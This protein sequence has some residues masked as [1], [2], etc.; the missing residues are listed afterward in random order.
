VFVAVITFN[1][2]GASMPFEIER[3]G[4]NGRVNGCRVRLRGRFCFKEGLAIWRLCHPHAFRCQLYY[5]DLAEV[6][7][8]PED[9]VAWLSMFLRWAEEAGVSVRLVNAG[10]QLAEW[11]GAV[12]ITEH[13]TAAGGDGYGRLRKVY[14]HTGNNSAIE[15]GDVTLEQISIASLHDGKSEVDVA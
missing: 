8:L 2:G 9:A 3:F 11:L 15:L 10:P 12:G 6:T 1:E 5:V 13:G 4:G 7:E 14:N